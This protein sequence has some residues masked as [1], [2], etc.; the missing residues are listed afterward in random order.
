VAD[1]RERFSAGAGYQ[2]TWHD[3]AADRD[4]VVGRVLYLPG[5]GEWDLLGTAWVDLYTAGDEAKDAAVE[6]T[7]ANLSTTRRWE[8]GDEL[9]FTYAHMRFPAID[10]DEFLPVTLAQ[11]AD[12]H[13]D[14]LSVSGWKTVDARRR[15]HARLGG[16]IDEDEAGGDTEL[17]LEVADWL[18]SDSVV[19]GTL[20]ASIGEFSSLYGTRLSYGQWL[21]SGRWDALYEIG[22]EDQAG[23]DEDSDDLLQQRLRASREF[24]GSSGWS[25]SGYAETRFY[26][27]E[28]SL[29]LGF[30]AQWSF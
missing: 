29:L 16:W 8:D 15:V 19:D 26:D 1:A 3:G 10:R 12:D 9:G 28:G 22:L 6:L 24:V 4:L 23:F 14:R 13:V 2:K 7:Q 20:F 27:D 17:G 25:V 18:A 11:L 21:G 5:Q 30:Y